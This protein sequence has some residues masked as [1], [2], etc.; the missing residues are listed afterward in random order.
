M[1]PLAENVSNAFPEGTETLDIARDGSILYITLS[2]KYLDD[3]ALRAETEAADRLLSEGEITQEMRDGRVAAAT[4][5]LYVR[6]RA[7]LYAIVNSLTAYDPSVRVMLSVNRRGVGAE[8]LRYDEIG[9]V[10]TG[11]A[12]SSLLEPLEF[13]GNALVTPERIVECVLRRMQAGELALV[14]DLFAETESGAGQKPTYA[15][16]EARLN[17]LGRLAGYTVHDSVNQTA[18]AAYVNVDVE[19]VD[20]Q[21]A[22]RRLTGVQLALKSEGNIYRLSFYAFL[23]AL[24]A[25]GCD[26]P[27][28]G[29]LRCGKQ[30]VGMR[31]AKRYMRL[32]ALILIAAM[33]CGCTA[34]N[35]Y[36]PALVLSDQMPPERGEGTNAAVF[37]TDLYFLSQDEKSLKRQ[38]RAVEYTTQ[39]SRAEAAIEALISGPEADPTGIRYSVPSLFQLNRV[40]LCG[41][42]CNVYFEGDVFIPLPSEWLGIRAAVAATVAAAEEI[43]SVNVFLLESQMGYYGY[44]LGCMSPLEEGLSTYLRT[45][46]RTYPYLNAAE[47]GVNIVEDTQYIT[48]TAALYFANAEGTLLSARNAEITYPEGSKKEE[49]AQQLVEML[50]SGDAEG[51]LE[52]SLPTDFR[53]LKEPNVIYSGKTEDGRDDTDSNCVIELVIAQPEA[54]NYN[55]ELMCGALT[56]TISGFI[57]NVSDV[58]ICI[59]EEK[60]IPAASPNPGGRRRRRK[61]RSPS[62]ARWAGGLSGAPTLRTCWAIRPTC[63]TRIRTALCCTGFRASLRRT[64]RM[65]RWRACGSC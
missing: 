49:I 42:V 47:S 56:M 50:R 19:F 26:P 14:Y 23:E 30:E 64:R 62:C 39:K 38:S 6:R 25:T 51:I 10:N 17:S 37:E 13:Q 24:G 61:I 18:N 57:P 41:D 36:P 29:A 4:E 35:D 15:E 22:A 45:M 28:A 12:A 2:E 52:P 31:T 9:I 33:L 7:G 8:R 63:I 3:S 5:A 32:P 59:G 20:A 53:L 16:F 48:Q 1:P 40:E 58:R 21:G 54:A 46:E 11:E 43:D 65:I 60:Q 44:S 55:E 27:Y 34:E